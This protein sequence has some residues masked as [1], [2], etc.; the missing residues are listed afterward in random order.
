MT[1]R[2]DA[3]VDAAWLSD[4]IDDPDLRVIHVAN[5]RAE[6]DA[7][8]V[9]GAAYA[10]GYDDFTEDRDGVRALVPGPARMAAS[11]GRLGVSPDQRI[12]CSAGA[13]SPWPARAY[14]VLRYYRFP[15]VHLADGAVSALAEAGVPVDAELPAID[16]VEIRL[17]DPDASIIALAA[18]VLA[19]AEGGPAR[20]VDCRS[21]GEWLGEDHG[22][23]E[24]ATHGPHPPRRA[25]RMGAPGPRGR[26]PAPA[27]PAPLALRRRRPRRLAAHLPLLRRWRPLRRRLVRAS[28]AARPR[29]GPQLRR[30]LVR[31]GRPPRSSQ[32]RQ[33]AQGDAVSVVAQG[34]AS[35]LSLCSRT[36]ACATHGV[37]PPEVRRGR[38]GSAPTKSAGGW[39]PFSQDPRAT[40]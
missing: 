34:D 16:P 28:R 27:R 18:D 11:L 33:V 14:W 40:R 20:I 5:D 23:A 2:S 13:R 32:S 31:M 38:G 30:L 8:H 37:D 22:H 6:Y 1:P 9:R 26:P 39:V 21:D 19:A 15:R 17:S 4:H 35:A 10:H 36:G 29:A 25:P 7:A 3:L 12:V 24:A